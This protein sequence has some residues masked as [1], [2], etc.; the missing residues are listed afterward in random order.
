MTS[1]N[2]REL[3]NH[4]HIGKSLDADFYFAHSYSSWECDINKYTNGLIRQ[5]LLKRSDFT[6]I[7]GKNLRQVERRLKN[8]RRKCLDMATLNQVA[9]TRS[10][11]R[12]TWD[13]RPRFK[14]VKTNAV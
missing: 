7:T 2:G 3:G 13:L 11:Y 6:C 5:H 9:C 1:D 10:S 12:Y 4:V 8:L 14:R